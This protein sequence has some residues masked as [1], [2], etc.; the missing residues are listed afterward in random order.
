MKRFIFALAFLIPFL[1]GSGGALIAGDSIDTAD[2]I[3]A[4]HGLIRHE[5]PVELST[6]TASD[7]LLG[8]ALTEWFDP[9]FEVLNGDRSRQ[10]CTRLINLHNQNNGFSGWQN[11]NVG[12][13][14]SADLGL[15]EL[16]YIKALSACGLDEIADVDIE[17]ATFDPIVPRSGP[18]STW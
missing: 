15:I 8:R 1:I 18:P 13:L 2:L 10:T 9:A 11:A 4:V 16:A 12:P 7:E 5:D 3:A 6:A 14:L 17:L